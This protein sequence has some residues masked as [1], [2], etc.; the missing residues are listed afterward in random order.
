MEKPIGAPGRRGGGGPATLAGLPGRGCSRALPRSALRGWR[1][2]PRK[3]ENARR[4]G[5]GWAGDREPGP[6]CFGCCA[7]ACP[8]CTPRDLGRGGGWPHAGHTQRCTRPL[9]SCGSLWWPA[10]RG[11]A[12]T[13]QW[14]GRMCSCTHKI[15]YTLV[16]PDTRAARSSLGRGKEWV[17][18]KGGRNR[19]FLWW[20]PGPDKA[21]PLEEAAKPVPC[22]RPILQVLELGLPGPNVPRSRPRAG[23]SD[24][25]RTLPTLP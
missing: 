3:T 16:L 13:R 5:L 14:R 12:Q 17:P 7:P 1:G 2:R 18:P 4:G 20:S 23:V 6:P 8:R 9:G 10:L 11:R 15:V 21:S 24:P 22:S 19:C 25:C